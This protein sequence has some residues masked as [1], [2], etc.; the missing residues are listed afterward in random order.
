MTVYRTCWDNLARSLIISTKLLQIVPYLLTTWNKQCE[1]NLLV[2]P[3]S[4]QKKDLS[5][6]YINR[7]EFCIVW[8]TRISFLD[9]LSAVPPFLLKRDFSQSTN[10]NARLS[11]EHSYLPTMVEL[12]SQC[13]YN[14]QNYEI[15]DWFEIHSTDRQGYLW[16]EREQL[17][18]KG[19]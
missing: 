4:F 18:K 9:A 19:L 14:N 2:G 1:H 5:I 3:V 13:L 16:L 17:V 10:S 7:S 8:T 12:C 11:N 15:L 6:D